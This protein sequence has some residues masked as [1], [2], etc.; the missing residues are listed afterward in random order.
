MTGFFCVERSP[1]FLEAHDHA[2]PPLGVPVFNRSGS[3]SNDAGGRMRNGTASGST[4]LL[5]NGADQETP[6][7]RRLRDDLGT[8]YA[9]FHLGP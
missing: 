3:I 5:L 4:Q 7:T 8:L 6:G 9:L 2:R 1:M